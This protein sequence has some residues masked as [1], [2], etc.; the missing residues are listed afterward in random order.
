MLKEGSLSCPGGSNSAFRIVTP[1]DREKT[2]GVSGAALLSLPV[3]PPPLVSQSSITALGGSLGTSLSVGGSL[4][5]SL[6]GSFPFPYHPRLWPA[7]PLGLSTNLLRESTFS[8]L[9]FLPRQS[10]VS[11]PAHVTSPGHA[12]QTFTSSP[13]GPITSP[14]ISSAGA[15]SKDSKL[16]D[17]VA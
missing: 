14:L 13:I 15:Y 12:P 8:L 11:L 9:P 5:G 17:I 4:P 7:P 10:S 1:K 6:G 16:N 3:P 2:E